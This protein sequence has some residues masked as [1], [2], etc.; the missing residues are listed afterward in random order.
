MLRIKNILKNMNPKVDF[1]FTNAKKWQQEI[2]LLRTIVLDC[3]L[4][5]E[6][7][8]AVNVIP[9]LMQQTIKEIT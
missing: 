4:N 1:Y 8:W 3:G 5:E 9:I 2:E 6:L 7:K